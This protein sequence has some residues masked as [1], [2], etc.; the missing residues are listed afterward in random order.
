MSSTR[1][2]WFPELANRSFGVGESGESRTWALD[3]ADDGAGL[4]VHELYADLG[5]T[6]TRTCRFPAGL[7]GRPAAKTKI[8]SGGLPVRPRTR[9]TLTS[10]TGALEESIVAT[11]RFDVKT[12]G[13]SVGAGGKILVRVELLDGCRKSQLCGAKFAGL[14]GIF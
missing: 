4:V 12:V 9:V 13:R 3:V 5:D 6:T 10:L 7:A 8:G 11:D 14:G 1:T 2:V